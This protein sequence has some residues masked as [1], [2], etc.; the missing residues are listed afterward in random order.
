MQGKEGSKQ[1]QRQK[2]SKQEQGEEKGGEIKEEVNIQGARWGEGGGGVQR[3]EYHPSQCFFFSP[4]RLYWLW[5]VILS[6][7]M[8]MQHHILRKTTSKEKLEKYKVRSS[9]ISLCRG[10]ELFTPGTAKRKTEN[11]GKILARRTFLHIQNSL[12]AFIC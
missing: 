11:K 1:E 7:C 4:A 5:W 12:L 6:R 10:K 2:G 3:S 9:P 8:T